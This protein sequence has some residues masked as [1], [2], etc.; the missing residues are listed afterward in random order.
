MK[1]ICAW[2]P[3]AASKRSAISA[4]MPLLPFKMRESA[5]RVTPKHWAA[6]VTVISPKYSRN[7]SPGWAGLCISIIAGSGWIQW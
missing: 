1:H 3:R 6:A 4:E 7:T 5:T 2:V